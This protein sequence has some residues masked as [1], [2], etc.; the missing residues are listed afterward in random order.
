MLECIRQNC[1]LAD[2]PMRI[3]RRRP[4]VESVA[5]P[6][7]NSSQ[8]SAHH[9]V[10]FET[11]SDLRALSSGSVCAGVS[12]RCCRLRRGLSQLRLALMIGLDVTDIQAIEA[13][14]RL[15][16]REVWALVVGAIE[17]LP[18]VSRATHS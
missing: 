16:G 5:P 6:V 4:E 12:L 14:T 7:S 1:R 18:V 17:E 8:V 2:A 15:P 13:G 9:H 11:L 3:T 10:L